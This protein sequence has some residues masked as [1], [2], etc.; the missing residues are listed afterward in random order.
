MKEF[1]NRSCSLLKNMGKDEDLN[2]EV[3]LEIVLPKMS[4]D[5]VMGNTLFINKMTRT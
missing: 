4:H 2:E 5:T 3:K 1:L